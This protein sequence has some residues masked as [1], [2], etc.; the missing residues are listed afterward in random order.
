MIA[1]ELGQHNRVEFDIAVTG[2][3]NMATPLVSLAIFANDM[4]MVF[5]GAR[6]R[7]QDGKSFVDIPKLD[8]PEGEYPCQFEVV[9][10]DRIYVPHKDVIGFGTVT[11]PAISVTP[12]GGV[13]DVPA[14]VKEPE[15]KVQPKPVSSLFKDLEKDKP[16]EKKEVDLTVERKFL[17][18]MK[19]KPSLKKV[20]IALGEEI[21][22]QEVSIEAPT[23]VEV[24][25]P[26]PKLIKKE[27]TT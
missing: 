26:K 10:G 15:V 11:T 18:R 17:E 9:I 1:L 12:T 2:L 14:A 27:I 3:S 6:E 13:P 16:A 22:K 24:S 4:K 21:N 25:K 8:L 19:E 23:K 20:G 5:S 7:H